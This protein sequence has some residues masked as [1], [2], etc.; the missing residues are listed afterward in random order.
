MFIWSYDEIL[1]TKL[2]TN[3]EQQ[4]KKSHIIA[5]RGSCMVSMWW[6]WQ[7]SHNSIG[8]TIRHEKDGT[9]HQKA[10][11]APAAGWGE[12]FFLLVMNRNNTAF[13]RYLYLWVLQQDRKKKICWRNRVFSLSTKKLKPQ[14]KN[15]RKYKQGQWFRNEMY[16]VA[17]CGPTGNKWVLWL[18]DRF[19]LAVENEEPDWIIASCNG[20][21][22][23]K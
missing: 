9:R 18:C 5:V 20:Q 22:L 14:K 19:R 6:I 12:G 7:W 10:N 3:V 8:D 16:N 23:L 11:S 15:S 13:H 17:A 21:A 1:A 2:P 4:H